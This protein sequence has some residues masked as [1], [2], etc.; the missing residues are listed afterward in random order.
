MIKGGLE[1]MNLDGMLAALS[2]Q[3][4]LFLFLSPTILITLTIYIIRRIKFKKKIKKQMK[5]KQKEKLK[6]QEEVKRQKLDEEIKVGK[7]IIDN[8]DLAL[9]KLAN[10]SD[11]P[12]NMKDYKS[13]KLK[14][15]SDGS[16]IKKDNQNS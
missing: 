2:I 8:E 14:F 10:I 12:D 5:E 9:N 1:L 7:Y 6:K 11:E 4:I 3:S 16:V 13:L 15:S